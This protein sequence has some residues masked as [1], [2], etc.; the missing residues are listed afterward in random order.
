MPRDRVALGLAISLLITGAALDGARAD[1]AEDPQ[2][3]ARIKT[4]KEALAGPTP[5][6][7]ELEVEIHG[8]RAPIDQNQVGLLFYHVSRIENAQERERLLAVL[9]GRMNELMAVPSSLGKEP[10][11]EELL[12]RIKSINLSE[13]ASAEEVRAKDELIAAIMAIPDAERRERLLKELEWRE[14]GEKTAV[15]APQPSATP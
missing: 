5:S 15:Y 11:D 3:A 7:N 4:M 13:T 12:E 2:A 10:T 9:N 8:L 1:D 14:L 6:L